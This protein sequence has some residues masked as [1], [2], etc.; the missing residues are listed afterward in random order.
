MFR[1]PNKF[2]INIVENAFICHY[3]KFHFEILGGK[4]T[5]AGFTDK[6]FKYIGSRY[7][8]DCQRNI[9]TANY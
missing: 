3:L 1:D 6:L 9:I 7:K 2:D 8:N 5:I 4:T